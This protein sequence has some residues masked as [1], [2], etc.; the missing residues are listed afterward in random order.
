MKKFRRFNSEFEIEE[1][2]IFRD[3]LAL[4]RT[5]L[6]N[7]RTLFAYIRAGIY[8]TVA[9]L[10]IL[11]LEHFEPLT[12]LGYSLF[13]ISAIF[14][15]FGIVRYQLLQ[16]KLNQYYDLYEKKKKEQIS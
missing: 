10:A 3:F 6:A 15:I 9:G 14:I 12:W 13:F 4:E 16:K 8:L 5:T 1:K 7:E 11:K 2:I